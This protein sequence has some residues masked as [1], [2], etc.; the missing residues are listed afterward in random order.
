MEGKRSRG[1]PREG[2]SDDLVV[3][4]YGDTKTRAERGQTSA[5]LNCN[6]TI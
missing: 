6:S 5:L 4:L 1:R 2:K 3:L